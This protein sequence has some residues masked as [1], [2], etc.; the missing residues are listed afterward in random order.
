EV[1]PTAVTA[2]ERWVRQDHNVYLVTAS[3]FND[4]LGYKIRKTLETFDSIL[5]NQLNVIVAQD[6]SAIQGHIMIDDCIDNLYAF[7][8][9]RICYDQPWNEDYPGAFRFY[10]WNKINEVIQFYKNELKW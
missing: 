5:V 2:I 1:N 4:M 8:K 3:H 9:V 10:D 7:S 6:K